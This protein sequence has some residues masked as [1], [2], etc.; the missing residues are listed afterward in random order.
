MIK[1]S[2]NLRLYKIRSCKIQSKSKKGVVTKML[3]EVECPLTDIVNSRE[4]LILS[5]PPHLQLSR[6]HCGR[7]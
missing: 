7:I 1:R 2:R 6:A 5:F 4:N 3:D